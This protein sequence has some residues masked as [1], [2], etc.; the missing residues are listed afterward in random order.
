[1]LESVCSQYSRCAVVGGSGLR[2]DAHHHGDGVVQRVAATGVVARS[3]A[4]AGVQAS[5]R[6]EMLQR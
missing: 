2:P 6:E 4:R 5:W 1:M 3:Y